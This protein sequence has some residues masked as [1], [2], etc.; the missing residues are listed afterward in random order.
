MKNKVAFL[1][2]VFVCLLT[3]DFARATALPPAAQK[4]LDIKFKGWRLA[5]INKDILAFYKNKPHGDSLNSVKGDWNGD[6]EMDYAVL[7]QD[8][9]KAE[10]KVVV[11]M[12]SASGYDSY[13]LEY[14]DCIVSEK[15]GGKGFDHDTNK[16]FR[17]KNDAINAQIWE[18]SGTTYVWE[19]KR[20][21][22]IITSD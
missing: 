17:Y 8:S 22:G 9:Q 7:L 10:K 18:K 14:A 16:S 21:R 6:G 5:E 11:L 12:K 1:A 19:N 20:F 4:V 2:L 3:P 15:K 13:V